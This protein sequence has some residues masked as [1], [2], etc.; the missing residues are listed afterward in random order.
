[1]LAAALLARS[2]AADPASGMAAEDEAARRLVWLASHAGVDALAAIDEA[3]QDKAGAL[4]GAVA[5]LLGARERS[6]A[7]LP[8][9][10]ALVAAAALGASRN[11]VARSR[12]GE[13]ACASID[14]ALSRLLR[15]DPQG[16]AQLAAA[17][18]SGEQVAAPRGPIATAMLAACGWL[19]AAHVARLLARFALRYRRLADVRLTP[20]GVL[21]QCTTSL[22]GRVVRK[23]ESLLPTEGLVRATR[24]VRYP[25]L[26]TYAG[27]VAL[28]LG[29]WLGVSWLVDGVRAGSVSLVAVG[30]L[31]VAGGIGLDLALATLL[32]GLKGRCRV[33]L[34]PRKGPAVCIANVDIQAA[35][36]MLGQLAK[37]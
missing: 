25:R 19:L 29:S 15:P 22:L 34:V 14:P 36:A 26:G 18:V 13:L 8:R 1:V 31:L 6:A 28:A 4:W 20:R 17:C 12:A 24:E 27:L 2:F 10:E 37:L 30:A 21:V 35:D 11:A 9:A 5:D 7:T 16:P 3:M 32:P 23:S 33:L